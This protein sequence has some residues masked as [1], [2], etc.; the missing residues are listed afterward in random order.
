[1]KEDEAWI[2]PRQ[3]W[4]TA[5]HSYHMARRKPGEK[6]GVEE[7]LTI[8]FYGFKLFPNIQ[9]KPHINSWRETEE[10]P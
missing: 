5:E 8:G 2:W 10:I 1:M 3:L 4:S 7:P 9:S 6:E